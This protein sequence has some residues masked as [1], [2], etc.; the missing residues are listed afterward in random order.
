MEMERKRQ[1]Q[2][3]LRKRANTSPGIDKGD[4][5]KHYCYE[6]TEALVVTGEMHDIEKVPKKSFAIEKT[7][8]NRLDFPINKMM[9]LTSQ[10]Q[11][12]DKFDREKFKRLKF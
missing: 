8:F 4:P 11:I 2:S 10:Y 3:I 5:S 1:I 7:D 6:N 12:T 9:F